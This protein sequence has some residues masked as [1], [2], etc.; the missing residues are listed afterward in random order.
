MEI[1][2]LAAGINN[3]WQR[4]HEENLFYAE[5]AAVELV[6]SFGIENEKSYIYGNGL[7]QMLV[8]LSQVGN[9]QKDKDGH[10]KKHVY[11]AARY[12]CLSIK[13][14]SGLA[15][16][17]SEMNVLQREEMALKCINNVMSKAEELKCNPPSNA[18][19]C[20]EYYLLNYFQ[21]LEIV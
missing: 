6:K 19:I 17:V 8:F 4:C 12:M 13:E 7:T 1:E 3:T 16:K 21:I 18:K 5:L 10:D 15:E 14:N 2:D 11:S 20:M 9:K